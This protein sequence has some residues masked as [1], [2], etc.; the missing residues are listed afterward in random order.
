M[1][2]IISAPSAC[3][4]AYEARLTAK[5][6]TSD[7]LLND[8]H[9]NFVDI[10]LKE[11]SDMIEERAKKGLISGSYTLHDEDFFVCNDT[12]K[13]SAGLVISH[14]VRKLKM[15][16]YSVDYFSSYSEYMGSWSTDEL[17]YTLNIRWG[18]A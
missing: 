6:K 2:N 14:I 16:G 8:M 4:I 10:V 15:L 12:V 1:D 7:E 17:D 11:I 18:A 5:E 13:L 3:S 9:N